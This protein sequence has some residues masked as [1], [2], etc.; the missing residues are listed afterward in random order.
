MKTLTVLLMVA[1]VV[2]AL[3]AFVAPLAAATTGSP[4]NESLPSDTLKPP[5]PLPTLAPGC[6]APPCGCAGNDC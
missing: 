6:S 5:L 4:A 3:V 1:L 2:V